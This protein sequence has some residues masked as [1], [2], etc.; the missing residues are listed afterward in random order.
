MKETTD[1]LEPILFTNLSERLC[2]N[3][4]PS[5]FIKLMGYVALDY[6]LDIR[7]QYHFDV[8][9]KIIINSIK[10]N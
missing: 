7:K 2:G 3:A 5:E 1:V 9:K 6:S 10:Y 4:K 8:C